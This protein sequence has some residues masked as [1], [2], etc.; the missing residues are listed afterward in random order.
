M[1]RP[2]SF[3]GGGVR[4]RTQWDEVGQLTALSNAAADTDFILGG[5][6]AAFTTSGSTVVRLRGI[7]GM[8]LV[9]A[10]SAGDGFTGAVGVGIVSG[11]AFAIGVTAVPMPNA[12]A[13]WGGWLFHQFF[14]ITSGTIV[15]AGAGFEIH[16]DIVIDSKA[17]R[18]AG[19]N[20]TIYI[21]ADVTE[22]GAAQLFIRAKCRVLVKL[23]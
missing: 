6:G 1:P 16:Q 23:P 13:S 9:S 17:M 15:A 5:A 18:K 14:D 19:L 4:R 20:E 12:Q 2:R 8:K 21:A 11:D 22:V 10:T 7:I 3:R